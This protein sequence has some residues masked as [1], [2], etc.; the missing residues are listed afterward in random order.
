M[1]KRSRFAAAACALS[2]AGLVAACGSESLPTETPPP[3]AVNPS[4]Q[5]APPTAP[6]SSDGGVT[7]ALAV[8]RSDEL[9]AIVTDQDGRVLYRFDKDEKGD[10]GEP[11]K[12]NCSGQ[13][14]TIWPPA[15]ARPEG[16]E[17]RGVNRELVNTVTRSDGQE[18]L[19]LAG[20]PLYRY[21]KD[22]APGQASGHKVR[23]TWFAVTPTGQKAV[24]ATQAG[25]LLVATQSD[26][27]GTI[28]VD[29]DGYTMYRFDRD[30]ADAK[31]SA[32]WGPCAKTWPPAVVPDG[33]EIVVDGIERDLVNTITRADGTKQLTLGGWPLYG[34]IEDKVSGD[35]KGNRVSGTWFAVSP[36]GQKVAP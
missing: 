22:T 19:T 21:S 4:A 26:E 29:A 18:Q 31:T 34:Y 6:P 30:S 20:W 24:E 9:G 1:T 5:A 28:V 8:T 7:S 11:A 36:S 35:I 25:A 13:C 32:C 12:S 33:E 14:A 27:L 16:V 3:G 17:L 15:L 23:S 2:V 10:G